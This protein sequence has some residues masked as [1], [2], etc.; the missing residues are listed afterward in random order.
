MAHYTMV[1]TN[2]FNGIRL[3]SIMLREPDGTLRTV[4]AFGYQDF[5]TRLS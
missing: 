5:K 2:T 4:R 1:K 3:P